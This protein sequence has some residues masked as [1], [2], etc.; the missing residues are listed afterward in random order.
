MHLHGPKGVIDTQSSAKASPV[1][2]QGQESALRQWI[3]YGT[4]IDS[5]QY[6]SGNT[7]HY[8]LA[9]YPFNNAY[10]IYSLFGMVNPNNEFVKDYNDS[11]KVKN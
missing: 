9:S 7:L 8:N 11:R 1:G 4:S 3:I 5:P 2:E 6:N 10:T